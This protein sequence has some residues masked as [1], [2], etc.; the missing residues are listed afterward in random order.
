MPTYE[1]RCKDCQKDFSVLMTI[2]E[3]E[4]SPLPTCPHCN[5]KN[6]GRVF[7]SVTVQTS[8]KS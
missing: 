5:S 7:T 6:V 4:K 2:T 3:Y 8:K 1:F